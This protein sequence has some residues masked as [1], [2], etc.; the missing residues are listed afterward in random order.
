VRGPHGGKLH[1][2]TVGNVE[3]SGA[4]ILEILG[5][6]LACA[7]VCQSYNAFRSGIIRL[8][9][10]G[11]YRVTAALSRVP[12]RKG[13]GGFATREESGYRWRA[14]NTKRPCR[15]CAVCKHPAEPGLPR[16]RQARGR[17]QERPLGDDPSARRPPPEPPPV[18]HCLPTE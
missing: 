10:K 6:V 12:R 14:G 17:G 8:R 18:E 13:A 15:Y 4:E 3:Q 2:E 9:S 1:A 7:F 16:G 11:E 5:F